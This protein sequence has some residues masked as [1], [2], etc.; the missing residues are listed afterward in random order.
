MGLRFSLFAI[1]VALAALAAVPAGDTSARLAGPDQVFVLAGQSNMR[2]RGLPLNLGDPSDT[3]L[4]DWHTNKWVV[5]SD[6]LAFPA[7]PED[8]IG[9][10]MTFGLDAIADLPSDTLGLVQCAIGSTPI[11]S[12]IPGRF[13]YDDCLAQIS[14]TTQ[15]PAAIL[16]LQGET[17]SMKR[18]KALNW[19]KNFELMLGGFRATFG[20]EVPIILAEIGNLN[21]DDFPFQKIVRDAQVAAANEDYKVVLVHTDDLPTDDGLHFTVDSYKTL[22][23]RF[24]AAWWAETNGVPPPPPPDFSVDAAPPSSAHPDGQTFQYTIS[25]DALNGFAGS[26]ILTVAGVPKGAKATFSPPVLAGG[27]TSTLT[28]TT[29]GKST[30]VGNYDLTV[31]GTNVSLTRTTQVAMDVQPPIPDFNP[32]PS[33]RTVHANH[34]HPGSVTFRFKITPVLDYTGSI[35]LSVDGLPP[36][37]SGSFAASTVQIVDKVAPRDSY[38]LTITG[39]TPKGTHPLTFTF[40]DGTL[41]HQVT[42]NVVVS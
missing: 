14:A 39:D 41:T 29:S 15:P 24:A 8:G 33:P 37:S 31:T 4:L 6:P 30:P 3:R 19:R 13:A 27:G 28:V 5:A 35:D 12:W 42:T 21:P 25:Y 10:G 7:L 16:F 32:A 18:Y 26:P 38:A 1:V 17:D 23:H 11:Y 40:T 22:G 36:S 34:L 2:G 20:P 9:P